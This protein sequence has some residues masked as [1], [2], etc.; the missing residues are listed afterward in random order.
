[1]T[2]NAELWRVRVDL[3]AL[4]GN[5]SRVARAHRQLLGTLSEAG[6]DPKCEADQGLGIAD[7]PV[8]GLLFWVRAAD[9]GS[10][11]RL[12]LDVAVRA[13]E[14]CG[15]GPDLYDLTLVPRHSVVL[16]ADARHYP[17]MPD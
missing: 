13:G 4:D 11:A 1:M 17:A 2:D 15:V 7:R 5:A 10:A 3:F 16:P 6:L 9:I 8:V 12:A 14:G